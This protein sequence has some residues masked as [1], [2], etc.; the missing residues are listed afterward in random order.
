MN[1]GSMFVC[2]ATHCRQDFARSKLRL[3]LAAG[4][5]VVALNAASSLAADWYYRKQG[6][7]SFGLFQISAE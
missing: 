3:R 6:D 1:P 5:G 2:A 7:E 4:L